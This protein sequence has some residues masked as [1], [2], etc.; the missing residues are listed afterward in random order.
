MG[1]T[2]H[3]LLQED[4]KEGITWL[5]TLSFMSKGWPNLACQRKEELQWGFVE[6][7]T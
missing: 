6:V 5:K 4:C 7:A 3:S 1:Q 2:W